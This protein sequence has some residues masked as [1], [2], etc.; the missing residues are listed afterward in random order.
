MDI[1]NFF[2][3][4]SSEKRQLS[5]QSENGD[6]TKKP[7]EDVFESSLKKGIKC[8]EKE[9]NWIRNFEIKRRN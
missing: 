6:E 5:D 2:T 7:R 4:G 1:T 9:I 8:V 3:Q